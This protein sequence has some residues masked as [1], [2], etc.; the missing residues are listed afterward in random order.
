MELSD[1]HSLAVMF[2]ISLS[3]MFESN[4]K[5]AVN[6]Y[7]KFAYKLVP[8]EEINRY[9][10]VCKF[11]EFHRVKFHSQSGATVESLEFG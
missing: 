9:I 10:S 1:E 11:S 2:V 7:R 4:A 5:E 3:I 6:L 8:L